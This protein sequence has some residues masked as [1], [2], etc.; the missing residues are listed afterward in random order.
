VF[1]LQVGEKYKQQTFVIKPSSFGLGVL[2]FDVSEL[3]NLPTPTRAPAT[4]GINFRPRIFSLSYA[5]T[6]NEVDS[7]NFSNLF[8]RFF[9]TVST[10]QFFHVPFATFQVVVNGQGLQYG[11]FHAENMPCY[12]D[13]INRFQIFAP[14]NPSQG[15]TFS[16]VFMNICGVK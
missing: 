2:P 10:D 6:Y 9:S 15:D 13:T 1:Q 5:S 11:P 3:G 14:E 12:S 4:F 16:N 7:F 8:V